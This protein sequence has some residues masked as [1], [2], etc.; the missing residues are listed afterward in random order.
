[1]MT[2]I[3]EINEEKVLNDTEFT[4]NSNDQ[5][6]E[7]LPLRQQHKNIVDPRSAAREKYAAEKK[8]EKDNLRNSN[9]HF[10]KHRRINFEHA[11]NSNPVISN[12]TPYIKDETIK[13]YEEI[14]FNK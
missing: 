3:Q 5:Q 4:R 13:T 9:S 11:T 12:D 10:N 14:M 1:K 2:N 6:D 7:N 8:K